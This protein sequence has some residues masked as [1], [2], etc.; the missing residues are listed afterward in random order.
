LLLLLLLLWHVV[1]CVENRIECLTSDLILTFWFSERKGISWIASQVSVCRAITSFFHWRLLIYSTMYPNSFSMSRR[2]SDLLNFCIHLCVHTRTC[3]TVNCDTYI[4]VYK[5]TLQSLDSQGLQF[6]VGRLS[7]ISWAKSE[8][9]LSTPVY[10]INFC[11]ILLGDL[12]V[13]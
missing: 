11:F 9:Y 4:D 8:L 3:E 12:S 10:F 7:T 2:A 6:L 1:Y 13:V 5:T